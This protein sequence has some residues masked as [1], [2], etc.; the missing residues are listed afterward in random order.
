M[1]KGTYCTLLNIII[2][3]INKS[4]KLHKSNIHIVLYLL[5]E[6]AIVIQ[7]SN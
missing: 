2:K 1:F 5:I 3:K 6:L 4:D 7:Q